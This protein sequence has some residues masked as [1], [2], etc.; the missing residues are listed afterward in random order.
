MAAGMLRADAIVKS[1]KPKRN[2]QVCEQCRNDRQRCMP[3]QRDWNRTETR[4]DRCVK[5]GHACGPP[6]PKPR[7][8]SRT[9]QIDSVLQDSIDA[10]DSI[11]VTCDTS[12]DVHGG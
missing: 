10:S 6:N 9:Y 7:R 12:D 2:Y 3:E 5:L 4:C 1:L 8:R 11:S